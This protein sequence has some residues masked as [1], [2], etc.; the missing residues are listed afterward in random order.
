MARALEPL[1]GWGRH[2]VV[3]A[4][5][6]HT[7]RLD[8]Q[9]PG[10][11]LSRG[12]GRAYG[13]AALPPVGADRPV[14]VTPAADR[15]LSFDES[16]GLL[17]AE[18]GLSLS[19]LARIYLPRGFFA[20][21]ST[22]TQYVTLGGM[23]ASDIHGKNHHSFGT[24][25]KAIRSL[26]M[27]VPDG[28]VVTTSPTE[29]PD[30]F[31]ATTGGMGLTG[32]ILEVELQ[33]ARIPTP[34]I[35]EES[36]PAPNLDALFNG[37]SESSDWPMTAAWVDTSIRGRGFGRGL[38]IRG[39]WAQPDEAPAEPPGT[40]PSVEVP[41]VFPSGVMNP[42]TIRMMSQVWFHRHGRK[43]KVHVTHPANHFWQ[44][45]MATNW[46]RGYGR[47]GFTQYQ[48]VLPRNVEVHK[49][50]LERFQALGGCSFINVYKDCG[51][52]GPGLLSFPQYGTS[53][54][55][56][57]PI[58]TVERIQTLI[59]G[60]NAFVIEHGGRVYL[61]KDAFTRAEDF[62]KMYPRLPEFQSVRDRWD[63]DRTLV[64]AQSV[65]LMGDRA[66]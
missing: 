64:S 33:L 11:L 56:D 65:R 62:A 58:T 17:R 12:L 42:L 52:A 55:L 63:P 13:D 43:K 51:E 8:R 16:A 57:I 60:L 15:I 21:V 1:A 66:N 47:R 20:P 18:A 61:A 50:F 23:V 6:V 10:A 44:L 38:V 40:R 46:Y 29:H 3:E 26:K 25:S 39:R 27:L 48:C 7:E 24:I 45:D 34:W 35:Y 14:L 28:R 19:E 49:Q 30:L 32:H 22:G 4:H 53:L 9:A 5:T 59:D 36:W 41:P 37:L 54:A 2:P 31:F